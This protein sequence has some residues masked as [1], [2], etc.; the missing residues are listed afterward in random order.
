MKLKLIWFKGQH[1]PR[2][3]LCLTAHIGIR[4]KIPIPVHVSDGLWIKLRLPLL[5]RGYGAAYGAGCLV[6]QGKLSS[7]QFIIRLV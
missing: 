3:C 1:V 5:V 4:F 6:H 7:L 2:G